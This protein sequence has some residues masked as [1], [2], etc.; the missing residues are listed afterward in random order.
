MRLVGCDCA[1]GVA[2]EEVNLLVKGRGSGLVA[3]G[4]SVDF[5]WLLEDVQRS[6]TCRK[7]ELTCC[8]LIL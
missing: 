4:G 1:G 3:G 8:K 6:F 2:E 5:I 7:Q